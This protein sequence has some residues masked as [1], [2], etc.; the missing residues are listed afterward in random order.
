MLKIDYSASGIQFWN[1]CIKSGPRMSND[2]IHLV[3]VK[4]RLHESTML[5]PRGVVTGQQALTGDI[6]Q[7]VVLQSPL[8]LVTCWRHQYCPYISWVANQ[9][10][11]G[12]RNWELH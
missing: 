4:S 6:G 10:G 9:I 1:Y 2:S 3:S 5:T 12:S 8:G 7:I 11:S